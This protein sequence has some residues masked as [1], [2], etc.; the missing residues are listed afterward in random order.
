[1]GN[2]PGKSVDEICFEMK[3]QGKSLERLSKKAEKDEK[4]ARKQCKDAITR[5]NKEA[6]EIYSYE[7]CYEDFLLGTVLWD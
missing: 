1:M 4:K 5:G 6:A 3:F 2:Q 7:E